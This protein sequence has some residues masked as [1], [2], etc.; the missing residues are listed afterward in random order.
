LE[1]IKVDLVM[2]LAVVHHLAIGKNIPFE[3]IAKILSAMGKYLIIEFVPKEDEKVQLMLTSGMQIFNEY[4]ETNFLGAFAEYF[5]IF[6][7][8]PISGTNRIIYLMERNEF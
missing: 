7:R 8:E 6:K 2:A 1:R 5:T 3:N 4:N